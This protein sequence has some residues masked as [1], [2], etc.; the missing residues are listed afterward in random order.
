MTRETRPQWLSQRL[1][2]YQ[3][4]PVVFMSRRVVSDARYRTCW[5]CVF[6]QPGGCGRT[7]HRYVCGQATVGVDRIWIPPGE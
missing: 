3:A 2:E 6:T 4:S 7:E 5:G 1:G